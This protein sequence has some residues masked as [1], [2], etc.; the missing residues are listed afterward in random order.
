MKITFHSESL[1]ETVRIKTSFEPHLALCDLVH[2]RENKFF[3]FD[4]FVTNGANLFS[5]WNVET[6]S[7]DCQIVIEINFESSIGVRRTL[8]L[9]LCFHSLIIFY[10]LMIYGLRN[11]GEQNH[12]N[13]K[14]HQKQSKLKG[15][16]ISPQRINRELTI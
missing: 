9:Y 1:E 5:I 10:C 15:K 8:N 16:I 3:S 11:D 6:G 13:N 2:V 7:S 4:L 12:F 14:Y